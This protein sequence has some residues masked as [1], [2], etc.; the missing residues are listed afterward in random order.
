[1]H[2]CARNI[3]S[4][5]LCTALTAVATGRAVA[6]P[7]LLIPSLTLETLSPA[8]LT[9]PTGLGFLGPDD[10]FV[11]EKNSGK[12]RRVHAGSVDDVLDLDVVNDREQGLLGIAL[13]P[14]FDRNGFVYLYYS[15]RGVAGDGFDGWIDNRL[16]RYVWD[17]DALAI[18]SSFQR[19]SIP[20]DPL[21]PNGPVHNGGP[22][23]FG[24][25]GKL[26]LATGDLSRRRIEQN[27]PG[28]T[29]SAGTGGIYRLN[30]DGS[31][32]ADNPFTAHT[33]RA[34]HGL[35][36]YGVRNSFGLAFDPVTGRLWDTENGP[37]RM[38]EINLVEAG[39]NSGWS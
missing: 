8:G 36:A 29:A 17:G 6:Q 11:I 34:L 25:D 26:Y 3:A 18:D 4:I 37:Q 20:L 16:E 33:D 31:I 21:Q 30:D 22:M 27:T 7:T 39:M 2:E 1:M 28:A 38:D 23:A 12:V 9:N 14:D 35:F 10:Y 32:P 15:A 5:S 19:L 13:H 24:P